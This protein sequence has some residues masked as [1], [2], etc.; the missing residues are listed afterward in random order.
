MTHLKLSVP[1]SIIIPYDEDRGFLKEAIS[2]VENQTVNCEIIVWQGNHCL[3]KNINNAM[4]TA[5]G[6]YIK[7]LAED[8]LLPRTA[9]YDLYNGIHGFDWVCADA[10]DFEYPN[11][12]ITKQIGHLPKFKEML[13]VNCIHGGTTLYRKQML[14]DV[15]GWD[16][17][18][19]TG[20]E[21]DLHLKLMA[22]GYKLNYI[23]KI[24][25]EYRIHLENK[26][27]NMSYEDKLE[28]RKYIQK[29]RDRYG[30]YNYSI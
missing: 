8:D 20:E 1:V 10:I 16:E 7:I 29:I 24:V 5:T 27:M 28:R 15:G 25:H 4:K 13:I 12:K 22:K 14:I 17:S 9:I 2:S 26:S 23:N 30:K 6:D 19:W 3:S 21:Y 11:G 18:L